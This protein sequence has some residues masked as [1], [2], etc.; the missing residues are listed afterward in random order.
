MAGLLGAVL[1]RLLDVLDQGSLVGIAGHAGEG[2]G[3]V[4]LP[5]PDLESQSGTRGTSV[6]AKGGNAAATVVDKELQIQQGTAA[7]WEA[8]QDGVPTGLLLVCAQG[9][10]MGQWR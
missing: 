5:G 10:G 4:Q 9:L 7:S 2:L 6:E 8:G 1:N 3:V